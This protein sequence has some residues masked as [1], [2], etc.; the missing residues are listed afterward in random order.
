MDWFSVAVT[1][2]II[3]GIILAS[4]LILKRND[5]HQLVKKLR[6]AQGIKYEQTNQNPTKSLGSENKLRSQSNVPRQ[7]LKTTKIKHVQN[8]K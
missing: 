3:I 2:T 5:V 1:L 8:Q 6:E 7:D 4:S